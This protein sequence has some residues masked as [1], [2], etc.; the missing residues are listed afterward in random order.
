V[1]ATASSVTT[2]T[3]TTRQDPAP[4][5]TVD[6][7]SGPFDAIPPPVVKAGVGLGIVAALAVLILIGMYAGY[8]IGYKDSEK[9]EANFFR[10]LLNPSKE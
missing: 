5:D 4:S 7:G 2:V 8:Y 6:P 3:A 9:A 10:A 1:T